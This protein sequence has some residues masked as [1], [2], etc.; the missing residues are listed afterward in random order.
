MKTTAYSTVA[1]ASLVPAAAAYSGEGVNMSKEETAVL[2]VV[3]AM[4]SSLEG[5]DIDGVIA[6]YEKGATIMFEPGE[7]LSDEATARQIF[8]EMAALKP[9]VTYAGHEVF[10]SGDLA[11]HIGPWSITGKDPQGES[12]EQ[13][14][15][16]VAVLRRQ[17]GGTWK[18][19]IDNPYAARLLNN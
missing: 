1:A 18:L 15:L 8:A 3:Q 10:L 16:S 4:A 13:S 14:G 11:V 19:V 9:K 7:P 12:V 17:P 2:S 6:T 5:G